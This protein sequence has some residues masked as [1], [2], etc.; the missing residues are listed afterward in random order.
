V[1]EQL[2]GELAAYARR[3]GGLSAQRDERG[4]VVVLGQVFDRDAL[5]PEA[6]AR[7]AELDRVAAAHPSF[8]VAVVV[9]TDRPIARVAEAFASRSVER[10]VAIVAGNA[11][12]LVDHQAR[13]RAR[14]ARVEIVFLTPEAL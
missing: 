5:R 8:P 4:V 1:G 11:L 12:P 3:A 7:L 2:L 6:A 14:N 9:H 13:D 10:R